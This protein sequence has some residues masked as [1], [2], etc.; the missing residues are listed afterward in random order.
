MLGVWS[1]TVGLHPAEVAL[2]L[3]CMSLKSHQLSHLHFSLPVF[4]LSPLRIFLFSSSSSSS[5]SHILPLLRSYY[6]SGCVLPSFSPAPLVS[7]ALLTSWSPV[8]LRSQSSCITVT[9]LLSPREHVPVSV[10]VDFHSNHE[11]GSRHEFMNYSS[12][13]FQ[14]PQNNDKN[15]DELHELLKNFDAN[16]QFG[17]VAPT[18]FYFLQM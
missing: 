4:A 8:H 13:L 3:I 2:S 1:T 16:L 6:L 5:I 14:I 7:K 18:S 9:A 11:P 10:N 17:A 15:A 12:T